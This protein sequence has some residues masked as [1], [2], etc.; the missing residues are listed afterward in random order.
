[1]REMCQLWFFIDRLCHVFCEYQV[2]LRL[3]SN[4]SNSNL[5]YI[6]KYLISVGITRINHPPVITIDSWDVHYS[7]SWVVY[8]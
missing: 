8:D 2:V 1:M 7:Q 6:Y 3:R 4:Y 5:I